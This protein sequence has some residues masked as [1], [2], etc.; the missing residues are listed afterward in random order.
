M[1]IAGRSSSQLT[2]IR[3][4]QALE[5]MPTTPGVAACE[6][7]TD[8]DI[9]SERERIP[10][11]VRNQLARVCGRCSLTCGWRQTRQR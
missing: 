6:G 5:R 8:F 1:A 7:N 2:Y 11:E 9:L 10:Q 4:E 3:E